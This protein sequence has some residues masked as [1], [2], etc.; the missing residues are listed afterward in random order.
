MMEIAT[1]TTWKES[2]NILMVI[3]VGGGGTN[4]VNYMYANKNDHV[5][6]VVCNTDRQHLE[7]SEVPT[8]IILGQITCKGLGAGTDPELGRKA[9]TESKEE[10]EAIIS[11]NTAMAFITCGMGGGTGTGAAPVIA[12]ICKSHDLLTVGVVTLPFYDEGQD[13]LYRANEGIKNM[14][15]NVDSLIIIQNQKIYEVFEGLNIFTAFPAAD[16]VLNTAVK[17]IVDIITIR[18][19]INTD[20]ADVKKVMQ[21]S[22][23]ALIGIGYGEG[24][25][26]A[27][28]AVDMAFHSP[29]LNDYDISGTTKVLVNISSSS[30]ETDGM[31]PEEL[32]QIMDYIATYTG[33]VNNQKRGLVKD[34]RLG[35]KICLTVIATGFPMG[36]L[37]YVDGN[38]I[39]TDNIIEVKDGEP[40]PRK[41]GLP[42]TTDNINI[43]KKERI[44]GKPALIV[45]SIEEIRACET[46]PAYLRRTRMLLQQKTK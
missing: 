1:P 7:A 30:S 20:F 27:K 26:R 37:P 38:S 42:L 19:I 17:S 32:S 25:D 40:Y 36:K 13:A 24:G 3:G 10:I 31:K 23:M 39:Q 45:S 29:L 15:K 14:K 43:T 21:D 6:Y 12:E 5:D 41:A 18:G 22:G 46:E 9:A 35:N 11:K 2:S 8:K 34:D 28:E 33:P 4:A 16:E 44:L